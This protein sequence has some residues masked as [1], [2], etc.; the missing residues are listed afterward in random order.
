MPDNFFLW[1][2]VLKTILYTFTIRFK[3]I[4]YIYILPSTYL[5]YCSLFHL[6]KFGLS[7]DWFSID[8]EQLCWQYILKNLIEL[9]S[10]TLNPYY[11]LLSNSKIQEI[12]EPMLIGAIK[13]IIIHNS[14]GEN[15]LKRDRLRED[16]FRWIPL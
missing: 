3:P 12:K 8:A 16:S 6:L 10:V 4:K 15:L 2:T 13:S 11:I 14:I 5:H 7:N 1:K 9:R